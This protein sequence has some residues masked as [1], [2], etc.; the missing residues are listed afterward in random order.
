[1][2]VTRRRSDQADPLVTWSYCQL[3]ITYAFNPVIAIPRT[4]CFEAMA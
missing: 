3:V 4:N 2:N 1:V